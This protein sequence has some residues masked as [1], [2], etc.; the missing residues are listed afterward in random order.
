MIMNAQKNKDNEIC[1]DPK[2]SISRV[3]SVVSIDNKGQ[4]LLPKDLRERGNIQPGDKFAIVS[5]EKEG[6][7][8]CFNLIKVEYLGNMVKSFLGPLMKDIMSE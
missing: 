1:C 5:W 7:V 2:S 4:I 6:D 3:E 8:C